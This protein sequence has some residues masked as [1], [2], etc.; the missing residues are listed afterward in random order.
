MRMYADAWFVSPLVPD[1]P[2]PV[3]DQAERESW[4]SSTCIDSQLEDILGTVLLVDVRPDP[5]EAKLLRQAERR[6]VLRADRDHEARH[7]LLARR[8]AYERLS[9]HAVR[10]RHYAAAADTVAD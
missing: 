4:R 2:R 8:P 1:R 9:R 7:D 5:L 3:A 10:A 6:Q